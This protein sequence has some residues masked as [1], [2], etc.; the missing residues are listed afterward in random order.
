MAGSVNGA[1]DAHAPARRL[2]RYRSHSLTFEHNVTPSVSDNS[3]SDSERVR[4]AE[5][6]LRSTKPNHDSVGTLPSARDP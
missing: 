2:T 6:S 5:R 4:C 1:R 3:Q